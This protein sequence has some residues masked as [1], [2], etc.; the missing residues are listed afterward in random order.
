MISMFFS[1]FHCAAAVLA[2]SDAATQANVIESLR[3][4]G[5]FR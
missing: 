4:C 2:I 3:M 1:G 5:C